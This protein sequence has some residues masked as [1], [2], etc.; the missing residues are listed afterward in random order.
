MARGALWASALLPASV[1]ASRMMGA[2]AMAAGAEVL[3]SNILPPCATRTFS[4]TGNEGDS[5][6]AVCITAGERD[7][8]DAEGFAGASGAD[9]ESFAT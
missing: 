8:G 2:A 5:G 9:I 4:S 6:L 3:V 7:S 1:S